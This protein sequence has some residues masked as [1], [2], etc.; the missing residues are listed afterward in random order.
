MF[1]VQTRY[2]S[3]LICIIHMYIAISKEKYKGK[4]IN[5]TTCTYT[6]PPTPIQPS[7]PQKTKKKKRKKKKPTLPSYRHAIPLSPSS[8]SLLLLVLVLRVAV[9]VIVIIVAIIF[10]HVDV[11]A[12]TGLVGEVWVFVSRCCSSLV[13]S[14]AICA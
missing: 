13:S 5:K 12:V 11:P 9:I 6:H 7:K 10:R 1:L 4:K 8:A 2:Q 3:R 14:L